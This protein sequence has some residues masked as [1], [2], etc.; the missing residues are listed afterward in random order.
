MTDHPN[1]SP[2]INA[3]LAQS[4]RDG[5]VFTKD[6]LP[7]STVLVQTRN[8]LY[9]L[10]NHGDR[11][12]GQGGKHLPE[13]TE[14]HVNGSTFG[15]SMIKVGFIGIGMCLELGRT[16]RSILTTSAIQSIT[17]VSPDGA[18]EEEIGG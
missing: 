12:V 9:T 4:E 15:G 5:G 6:I 11:W 14:V 16:G 8:T 3:N 1:L 17:I 7:G 10:A 18:T 13:A 2:E